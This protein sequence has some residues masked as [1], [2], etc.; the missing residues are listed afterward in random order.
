M[1]IAPSSTEI[2]LEMVFLDFS[3]PATCAVRTFC[4]YAVV[5]E[6]VCY[7]GGSKRLIQLPGD[8]VVYC[9]K[10]PGDSPGTLLACLATSPCTRV[11]R[12]GR[13]RTYFSVPLSFGDLPGQLL[14]F[15]VLDAKMAD[16]C[17]LRD[18]ED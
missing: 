5:A 18:G 14:T 6:G 3:S 17:K 10:R 13:V 9:S 12:G 7:N 16:E 1:G 11:G 4:P 2:G 8:G 15:T